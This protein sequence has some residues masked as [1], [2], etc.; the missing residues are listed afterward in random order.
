MSDNTFGYSNSGLAQSLN[1]ITSISDGNGASISDGNAIF[2]DTTTNTATINNNLTIPLTSIITLYGNIFIPAYNITLTPD[3]I[4]TIGNITGITYDLPTKTTSILG[5]SIFGT[6]GALATYTTMRINSDILLYGNI[7]LPTFS[8][9][10]TP[11]ILNNMLN[12]INNLNWSSTS[13]YISTNT[14]INFGVNGNLYLHPNCYIIQGTSGTGYTS[15]L[16]TN[17]KI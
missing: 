5:N 1:G 3:D 17:L 12:I 8:S 16:T 13:S 7:N 14:N 10:I 4:I 15:T 9:V 2:I 11:I 6:S